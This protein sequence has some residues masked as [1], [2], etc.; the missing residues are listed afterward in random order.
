MV[1]TVL[2]GC[3]G[4]DA[5]KV[6][7]ESST[8]TQ[9]EGLW[10]CSLKDAKVVCTAAVPS[11]SPKKVA[12]VCNPQEHSAECPDG[13]AV[14]DVPGL[15]DLLASTG[16]AGAFEAAPWAC[17]TTGK[18]ECQCAREVDSAGAEGS[19]AQPSSASDAPYGGDAKE[20]TGGT[21]QAGAGKPG[22]QVGTASSGAQPKAPATCAVSAWESYFADLATYEYTKAGAKITFPKSVFDG[23]KTLGGVTVDPGGGLSSV[24][25]SAG[26]SALRMQSWL[27]AVGRGCTAPL[28]MPIAAMCD[29][30]ARYA[31]TTGACNATGAW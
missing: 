30:A 19:P 1:A 2:L 3:G 14:N 17:L 28:L 22:S 26:E 31:P 15:K 13:E 11:E 6:S 4:S 7:P 8:A 25:C 21:T 16:K 23:S 27:D 20:N 5:A 9:S 18:H 29:Q 24:S 12:Y 10:G